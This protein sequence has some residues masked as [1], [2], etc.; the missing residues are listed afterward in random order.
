[1]ISPKVLGWKAQNRD[2]HLV[3]YLDLK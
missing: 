3:K 1:L 2:T